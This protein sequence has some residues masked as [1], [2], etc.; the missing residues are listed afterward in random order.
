MHLLF[1]RKNNLQLPVDLQLQL[2][3]HTIVPILTYACEIWGFE[4]LD[5]IENIHTDFQRKITNSR[6]SML[7]YMLY[8]E[9]GRI[10][11]EATIKTRIIGFWNKLICGKDT[12][13]SFLL[14]QVL[15]SYEH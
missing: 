3:D 14:Y 6:K 13:L 2:F 15:K 7:L 1:C 9:L 8:A 4:C 11:L 10:P 5:F 12:K